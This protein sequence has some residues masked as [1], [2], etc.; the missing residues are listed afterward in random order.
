MIIVNYYRLVYRYSSANEVKFSKPGAYHRARW[1]AKAIYCLKIYMSRSV[2][3]LTASEE[4]SL[5]EICRFLIL[6]YV[7]AHVHSSI[8]DFR[9]K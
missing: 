8:S 5:S 2:F 9:L 1:M 7:R 3:S 6:V 4:K